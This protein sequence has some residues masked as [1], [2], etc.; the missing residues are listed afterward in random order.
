LLGY[1]AG[2]GSEIADSLKSRDSFELSVITHSIF[3]G[4]LSFFAKNLFQ[5]LQENG[6]TVRLEA[7][8]TDQIQSR[9][10]NPSYDFTL[11]RWIEITRMRMHFLMESFIPKMV[12][13]VDFAGR[14]IWI[15]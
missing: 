13:W 7:A 1:E 8:K 10:K 11:T 9:L 12:L 4:A 14:P 15:A 6:F 5:V 2:P 3:D